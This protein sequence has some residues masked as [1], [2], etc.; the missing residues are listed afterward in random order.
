M[1]RKTNDG[2]TDIYDFILPFGGHLN[3]ENRWV[4]LR[5]KIR[6]DIIEEEYSRH[7]QNKESGQ[8]AYSS[9]IAFGSLFI[10]RSL[11]FTD[12]ELVEQIAENPY[13]QYFMIVAS[14][15]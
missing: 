9:D 11:K 2:Q 1:Y 7:F 3:K 15:G 14:K 6:W 4:K 10:Q 5:E 12:R 13:M 8:E